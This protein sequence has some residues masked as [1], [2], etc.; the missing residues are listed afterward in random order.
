LQQAWAR[1]GSL[2]KQTCFIVKAPNRGYTTYS[3]AVPVAE[4][5]AEIGRALRIP[6]KSMEG[7]A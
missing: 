6:F 2:W 5:F 3:A 4:L 7:A 1:K